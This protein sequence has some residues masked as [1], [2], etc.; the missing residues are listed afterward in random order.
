MSDSNWQHESL[1]HKGDS[2]DDRYRCRVVA[3]ESDTVTAA[4]RLGVYEVQVKTRAS[5]SVPV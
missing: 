4:R 1:V 3:A 5:P 2:V